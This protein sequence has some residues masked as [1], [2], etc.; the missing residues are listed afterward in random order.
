MVRK[1]FTFMAKSSPRSKTVTTWKFILL[2]NVI[3]NLQNIQSYLI[4][5]IFSIQE[6]WSHANANFFQVQ[7]C[8]KIYSCSSC[9][10]ISLFDV[11]LACCRLVVDSGGVALRCIF[12]LKAKAMFSISLVSFEICLAK[13]DLFLCIEI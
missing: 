3:S 10:A 6:N 13:F 4:I 5:G 2:H 9:D 12:P 7:E 1:M 11:K 8:L